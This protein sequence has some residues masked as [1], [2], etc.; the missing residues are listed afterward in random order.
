MM[1]WAE[2]KLKALGATTEL[3]ELGD[4]VLPDGSKI[5]LPPA[6]IGNFPMNPAKK[7]LLIYGHLDVQPAHINDGWDSEPF[8]LTE[9]NGKLYGRGSTDDKGP[10]LCWMH[11]IEGFQAIGEEVPVNIKFVF[12]GAYYVN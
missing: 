8:V 1:K 6:L 2:D 9:R 4:Q 11:A 10:V 3:R 5:A 12:E 7:T